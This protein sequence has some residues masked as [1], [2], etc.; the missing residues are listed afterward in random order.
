MRVLS[1]LLF[2]VV[3]ASLL[4][5]QSNTVAERSFEQKLRHLETNGAARTPDQT[6]TEFSEQE[7]NDYMRSDEVQLPEGVQR[8][9]FQGQPNVITGNARVDF[10]KLRAGTMSANPLLS[11]FSGIH[12]VEVTAHAHGAGRKGYVNV[13]TVTLDGVEIPRFVLEAFVDKYVQPRYPQVGLD[14]VFDLP[15]R[16]DTATVGLHKVTLTQK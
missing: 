3:L 12:D 8:V 7:I 11:M 2:N 14:S 5:A 10:D 6:P 16:I 9:N 13:D 15:D 4:L 1:T